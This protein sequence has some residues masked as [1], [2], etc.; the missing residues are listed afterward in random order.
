M[1]KGNIYAA[2][3]VQWLQDHRQEMGNSSTAF[4][5]HFEVRWLLRLGLGL[6]EAHRGER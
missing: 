5:G 3:P 1:A 4:P 2:A 6:G